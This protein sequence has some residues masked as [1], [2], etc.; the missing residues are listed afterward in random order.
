MI[1]LS[2][3]CQ[4]L[5]TPCT[6]HTLGDLLRTYRPSLV[7]LAE[8]KCK[9]GRIE[10]LKHRFDY[11]GCCVESQGQ[12][13]G[14]ALLWTKS[15]SVQ[16]QSFGH[17][18]IDATVYPES[19]SEAWRFTGFY[20]FAD[21]ASRQLS[22]D[23]ILT[24]KRQSCRP[25]LVAGDFN[26]ILCETEKKGGRPR[27]LWQIRNFR[28]ALAT[29]DLFDLGFD[30]E[31][32]TWCNQHPEPDTIYERLDR[33]CSDSSWQTR[34]PAAVVRHIPVVSSDHSA[35]LID[36]EPAHRPSRPRYKPFRFEAAWASSTDC[37]QV[38]REGWHIL[39]DS[40]H[41]PLLSKLSSCT[42]R[43]KEWSTK[44]GTL[45]LK[46][47]IQHCEAKLTRIRRQPLTPANKSE[48]NRIRGELERL[49]AE[50]EVY[51]KQRGKVHWLREGDRNTSFFHNQANTRRRM[52]AISNS[53]HRNGA[54]AR[55]T[56]RYTT[57]H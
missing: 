13:G 6:V 49:L 56:E 15:V 42:S 28:E 22:W 55:G 47:Q 14:L 39:N 36:I 19:K 18:H 23:L 41:F 2:W 12:S 51:W 3:N 21:T 1:L 5:G 25:W 54:V 32:F 11:F 17:H 45:S 53:E 8:T 43:L 34:F 24:L 46:Q 16:L 30:G 40:S 33:A 26:E 7:F 27:P 9:T 52:N 31:P 4:G 37:E 38:I 50:D 48:A 29:N 35:L 57:A 20:G 10:S 44:Q